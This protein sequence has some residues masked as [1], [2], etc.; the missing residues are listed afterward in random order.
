MER[1]LQ[2]S[3]QE[4]N[5]KNQ[6]AATRAKKQ[7]KLD[8]GRK[9]KIIDLSGRGSKTKKLKFEFATTDLLFFKNSFG[10]MESFMKTDIGS[11]IQIQ[12]A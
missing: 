11:T 6:L 12:K 3:V 7:I 8:E 4:N 1:V 9:Y 5:Y 10:R 2:M